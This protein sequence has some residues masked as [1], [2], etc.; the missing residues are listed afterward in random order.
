MQV[1]LNTM[2]RRVCANVRALPL[3][4]AVIAYNAQ[5]GPTYWIQTQE[6]LVNTCKKT[7]RRKA[8]QYERPFEDK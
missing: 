2:A 3:A 5:R 6:Q 7:K 8:D 4:K 1:G